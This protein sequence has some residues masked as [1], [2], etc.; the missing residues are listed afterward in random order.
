MPP[1]AIDDAIVATTADRIGGN[2]ADE[3][4]PH[5]ARRQG[6]T[7]RRAASPRRTIPTQFSPEGPMD[8][9]HLVPD[10]GALLARHEFFRG[11]SDDVMS[12]LAVH[13][14]LIGYPRGATIFAKG[15]PG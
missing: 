4:A 15:D 5:A 10:K 1:L 11:V 2:I 14:R 6:I 7:S 12:K 13:A 9:D 8:L 3:S